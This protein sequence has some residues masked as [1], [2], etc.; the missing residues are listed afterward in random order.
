MNMEKER[1]RV[2]AGL[3]L[4]IRNAVAYDEKWRN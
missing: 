1:L 3:H 2:M 4:G